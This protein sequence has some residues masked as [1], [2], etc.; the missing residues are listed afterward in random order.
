MNQE[1]ILRF[2]LQKKKKNFILIDMIILHKTYMFC[3]LSQFWKHF[4][5]VLSMIYQH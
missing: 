1:N 2:L 3:R 5:E 4:Y